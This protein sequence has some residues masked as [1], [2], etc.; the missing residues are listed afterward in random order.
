MEV[1][2]NTGAWVNSV[3]NPEVFSV[4]GYLGNG[5]NYILHLYLLNFYGNY[6]LCEKEKTH[7]SNSKDSCGV[8]VTLKKYKYPVT[9][10]YATLL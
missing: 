3:D 9:L 1:K 10:K 5:V 8:Y 4:S 7:R 2:I 6:F